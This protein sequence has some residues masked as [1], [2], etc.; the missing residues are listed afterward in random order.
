[1]EDVVDQGTTSDEERDEVSITGLVKPLWGHRRMLV[2]IPLAVTAL[3]IVLSAIVYFWLPSRWTASLE[4]S[5]TFAG[6][7][8]G[9]YPNGLPFAPSDITDASVLDQVFDANTIQDYC[10]RADF[11][12]AFSIEQSSTDLELI[13]FDYRA[14]LADTRITPVDRQR[15]QDEY[16]ARRAGAQVQYGLTFVRPPECRMLPATAALKV[17]DDVLLT[18]ARDAEFKR[19]V[20]KQRVRILAPSALDVATVGKQSLFVRANLVWTNMDRVIRN[21]GEVE[22]LPGAELVRFGEQRDSLAGVKARME[23]LQHAHLESLMT[24]VGAERDRDSVRWVEDALANA[25]S[26]QQV[27]QNRARASLDALREYSGVAPLPMPQRGEPQR[28]QGGADVQSLTPQIDRTF[29][30]R[31]LE[32]SAPNAAFRQELTRAMVKAS[33]E[34]V[35]FE[36]VVN[37]Y[38]Q[39]LS[40][41]KR[42]G[43]ASSITE[44]GSRLDEIVVEGKELTRRFNGLYEEW[45]RVSF[46]AG[47]E[48]YRTERPGA[49]NVIRPYSLR[50][51]AAV[52]ALA[53]FV[54]LT[55]AVLAALVHTRLWPAIAARD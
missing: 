4:F 34:A 51:Y 26:R 27:A 28:P 1:L 38:Q 42:G 32:M 31:I 25:T 45:S 12:S 30:D 24:S 6:A 15:L 53:F 40:A 19:G 13:D 20:L 35:E 49:V 16:R 3:A 36:S 33:L 46:R 22:A 37:H 44:L 41:L 23:D 55:F 39:L 50:S 8:A 54:T 2:V 17:L 47:P 11:R 7:T 29:V 18:W 21:I 5:P 10:A 52:I 9:R 14:R 43:S 48:L